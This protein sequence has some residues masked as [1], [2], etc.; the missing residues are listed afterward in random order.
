V[1]TGDV[2][3]RQIGRQGRH[4]VNWL[5]MGTGMKWWMLVASLRG[6]ERRISVLDERGLVVQVRG[7]R[8][9]LDVDVLLWEEE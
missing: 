3:G 1:L 8:D 4:Y 7:G 9:R 6:G 2:I 5:L